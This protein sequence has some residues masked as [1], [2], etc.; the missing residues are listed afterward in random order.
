MARI[1]CMYA[2]CSVYI[3]NMTF[4]SI[5]TRCYMDALFIIVTHKI[6]PGW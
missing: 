5:S 6:L 4:E 2:K 3:G 1:Q